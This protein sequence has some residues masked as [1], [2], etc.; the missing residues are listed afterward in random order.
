MNEEN[1]EPVDQDVAID[2]E[3]AAFAEDFV[4]DKAEDAGEPDAAPAEGEEPAEG[5]SEGGDEAEGNAALAADAYSPNFK[6]KAMGQEKEFDEW[7]KK[8]VKDPET[9]KHVKE[10]Y[11]KAHGLE[12]VKQ[13][14]HR[15]R[16]QLGEV[17]GHLQKSTGFIEESIAYRDAKD[18]GKLFESWKIDPVEVAKWLSRE[19]EMNDPNTPPHVRE[20]Y[21]RSVE[22]TRRNIQLERQNR[23]LE[24]SHEDIATQNL[25][26]ELHSVMSQ[27]DVASVQQTIDARTGKA[28][29]FYNMVTRHAI[30]AETREGRI[31]SADEAVKEVMEEMGYFLDQAS[32]QAKAIP[33]AAP[34]A[35]PKPAGSQASPAGHRPS[36]LPKAGSTGANPTK[37]KIGSVE[38]LRKTYQ[39]RFVNK[40][41]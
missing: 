9:E 23:S 8:L 12:P 20:S 15:T 29:S 30:A 10:L 22:A 18:F 36:T 21:L 6:F 26:A 28:G 2:S 27:P 34:K 31:L 39:E 17:N 35:L 5:G 11:E 40:A 7:A 33:G 38:D 16:E 32:P 3:P 13:K 14:L 24:S 19:I 37:K 1:L 4:P 41:A 25:A